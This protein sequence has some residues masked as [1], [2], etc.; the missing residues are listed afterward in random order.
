MD[1]SRRTKLPDSIRAGRVKRN[2]PQRIAISSTFCWVLV[3]ILY[4]Y[5]FSVILKHAVNIPFWDEWE[6]FNPDALPAGFTWHWLFKFHNE[7]RIVLTKLLAWFNLKLFGLDFAKQQLFNFGLFGCLLTAIYRQTKKITGDDRFP[8][9]P[10]FMIFLLSPLNFQNHTWAFQS[11]FHLVMLFLVLALGRAFPVRV[12]IRTTLQF[13]LFTILALYSFSAGAVFSI[14]CLCF[15]AIYLMGN[16]LRRTLSGTETISCLAVGCGIIGSALFAWFYGYQKPPHHPELVFPST[17]KF[18]EYFL[19]LVGFGFGFDSSSAVTGT[20]M[21]AVCLACVLLPVLA[22]LIRRETRWAPATWTVAAGTAS[23]LAILAA[24]TMGRANLWELNE[25]RYN[26]F[27]FMLI[28][29]GTLAWWLALRGRPIRPVIVILLWL[30]CLAG[31][32]DKRS[33]AVYQEV[34]RQRIAEQECVAGCVK[35]DGTCSC[36]STFDRPLN[37]FL[38]RAKLLGAGFVQTIK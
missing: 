20:L 5:H 11:Q 19:N 15:F 21:G 28:P 24:I 33:F 13:S 23:I 35:G 16:Y 30:F 38:D 18:W 2:G 26:E 27:A 12:T 29:Y 14:V 22:L 9:F 36:P 1:N 4:L 6:Y 10:L 3:L 7:H 8:L 34:N 25:S 32:W 31:Y 37:D 17:T